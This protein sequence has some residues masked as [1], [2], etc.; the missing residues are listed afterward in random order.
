MKTLFLICFCTLFSFTSCATPLYLFDVRSKNYQELN[1]GVKDLDPDNIFI[2]GESHYIKD[3]QKAQGQFIDQMVKTHS[4]ES[5]FSVGWEFLN[6]PDQ[7]KI[8][9]HLDKY[10]NDE[11]SLND[12]FD[13]LFNEN[14]GKHTFYSP[15]FENIKRHKG[16]FIAT[17]APREWKSVIVKEGLNSLSSDKIPAN[18]ERGSGEY[19]E[20]FKEAMAGHGSSQQ[21]ENYFLAQSYTD[22]VMANSL[23]KEMQGETIFMVVGSFHSDYGHG[24]PFY[25]KKLTNKKVRHIRFVDFKGL[26]ENERESFLKEHGKY[27]HRSDIYLI[28]NK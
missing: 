2:L 20:R 13:R 6:Y 18:M 14:P 4:L 25:L 10:R 27:G 17:N 9:Q 22:A 24:L 21:L 19:F 11:I 15:L 28:V 8:D 23:I 3:I 5:H 26:S 7:T 12:F 16:K 1:Q